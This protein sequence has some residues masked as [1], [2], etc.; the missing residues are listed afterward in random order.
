MSKPTAQCGTT[1]GY[2][3]HR[4]LHE[5]ICDSCAKA[6]REYQQ[7]WR[8]RGGRSLQHFTRSIQVPKLLLAEMYLNV[9]LELQERIEKELGQRRIDTLVRLYDTQ[10]SAA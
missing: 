6:R 3:R 7:Q 5:P 8:E 9:P 2:E 4:R 10:E 1:S